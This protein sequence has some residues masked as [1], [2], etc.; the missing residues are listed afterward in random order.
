MVSIKK[1][2]RFRD[3]RTQIERE[4]INFDAVDGSCFD[5]AIYYKCDYQ[6]DSKVLV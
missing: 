5:Y 3:M 6:K 2:I 1:N 4:T